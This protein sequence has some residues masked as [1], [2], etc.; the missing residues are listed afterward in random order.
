MPDHTRCRCMRAVVAFALACLLGIPAGLEAQ[1]GYHFT[2]IGD[3]TGFSVYRVGMNNA[4][5]VIVVRIEGLPGVGPLRR[6]DGQTFTLVAQEVSTL[7]GSINDAGDITL[8][9]EHQQRSGRPDSQHQRRSGPAGIVGGRA[10]I[11]RKPTCPRSARRATRCSTA[12]V[13]VRAAHRRL[14]ASTSHQRPIRPYMSAPTSPS[15][16]RAHGA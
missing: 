8:R 13:A 1:S 11:S 15:T 12:P 6:G 7:C 4:G 3:T 14:G 16:S 5:T 2:P 9:A 10:G